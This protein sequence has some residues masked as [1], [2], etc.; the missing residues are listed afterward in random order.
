[1]NTSLGKILLAAFLAAL[2][3]SGCGFGSGADNNG[4]PVA[5]S[6]AATMEALGLEADGSPGSVPLPMVAYADGGDLWVSDRDGE[7]RLIYSGDNLGGVRIA[8]DGTRIV[9]SSYDTIGVLVTLWEINVDGTNPRRLITRAELLALHDNPQ[10]FGVQVRFLAFIPGKNTLAFST[11]PYI[12]A[13]DYF[14]IR[15]LQ[16]LDLENGMLNSLIPPGESEILFWYSPDGS[17]IAYSRGGSYGSR[18]SIGLMDENGGERRE[19]VIAYAQ[20]TIESEAYGYSIDPVI[21][22]AE[23]S[24]RFLA[25]IPL[26]ETPEGEMGMAVSEISAVDGTAT[27]LLKTPAKISFGFFDNLISPDLNH[28]LYFKQRDETTTELHILDLESGED[29]IIYTGPSVRLGTRDPWSPDSSAFLFTI[30]GQ[31]HIAQL[32]SGYSA[33]PVAG[34]AENATWVDETS[35]LVYW[36]EEP[37][38]QLDFIK[39]GSSPVTIVKLEERFSYDVHK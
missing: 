34:N 31:L 8:P 30:D 37:N 5:T 17:K 6:V 1:M 20:A 36:G 28:L 24:S 38:F 22:W 26:E 4:D 12:P 3:F 11:S 9:F 33:V 29:M 14:A 19:D 27:E 35:I 2:T 25:L 13:T 10:A 21:R 7:K 16:N 39:I 15:D 18:D 23:D 32:G